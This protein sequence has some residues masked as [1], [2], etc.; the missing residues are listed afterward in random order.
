MKL[1]IFGATGATGKQ[2]VEQ[3]LA[4]GNHVVVYVRNPSKLEFKHNYLTII[5]G[6]KI[7]N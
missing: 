4:K 3:A 6:I 2:L 1:T 7:K 5:E